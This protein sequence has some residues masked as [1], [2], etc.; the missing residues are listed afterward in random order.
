MA[1]Q[2]TTKTSYG[3]R[4]G[5]SLSGILFG[6]VLLIG[7]TALL[8]WNEGRAVKTSK[9]LNAAGKECVDVADV[10]TVDA[11]LNGSLIHAI[12]VVSTEDILK[13]PDYPVSE[14]A[15]RIVRDVEYYQWI[16]STSSTTKDKIGGGQETVTTYS[17]TKNWTGSPVNSA[18]FKDPEYQG[19]NSVIKKVDDSQVIAQNVSF[20]AYQLP[21]SMIR[22]IPCN[23]P[24]ELPAEMAADS[25][26]R[27]V[28][29]VLYYGKDPDNPQ[30]GDVRVTFTKAIG[31]QASILA[32]VVG[33]T[34]EPY[35]KNG[36]SLSTLSMGSHS[37]ENMF[38]SEKAANKTWL[39]II[40]IVGIILAISG[41]RNIFDILVTLLKVL[42]PLA[43]IAGLGVN[44]VTGVLGF[45]WALIII[46]IAWI[47]YRPVLAIAL[48]VVGAALIFWMVKK[49]RSLPDPGPVPV[50]DSP[51]E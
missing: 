38:E 41:F 31:G 47:V 46:V 20:G 13:D 35:T 10:S 1:Y 25:T 49:S 12:A 8:W 5:N 15:I 26:M 37:M 4:L 29:N 43:K 48:L 23:T 42:P 11:S 33:N 18:E 24:V 39:W 45:V 28:H 44:L 51:A 2:E 17:Y 40:R 9:M 19:R 50:E 32:K 30:V 6:F 27:V 36:K 21:A 34:F 14:N 22:S 3:K 7:A 16:E